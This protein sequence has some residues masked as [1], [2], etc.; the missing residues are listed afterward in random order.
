MK[1]KHTSPR[2]NDYI[3]RAVV[4]RNAK[5]S[6]GRRGGL[7]KF[8]DTPVAILVSILKPN[9]LRKEKKKKRNYCVTQ[10]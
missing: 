3:S 2:M 9:G 10:D 8:K 4:P 5:I 6:E 1:G 7:V